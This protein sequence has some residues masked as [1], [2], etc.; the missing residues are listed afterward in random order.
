MSRLWFGRVAI[1]RFAGNTIRTVDVCISGAPV[2]S[3]PA[4]TGV[5]SDA[6][7]DTTS[8]RDRLAR[9]TTTASTAPGKQPKYVYQFTT[10]TFTML[11]L[12]LIYM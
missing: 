11:N 9:G 12:R 7:V 8:L 3:R 2:V 4:T 6:H 1:F 5:T 10:D